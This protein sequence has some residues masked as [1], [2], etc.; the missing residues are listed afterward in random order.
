[1]FYRYVDDCLLFAKSSADAALIHERFNNA[2]TYVKYEIEHPKPDGSLSLLDFNLSLTENGPRFLPFTKPSKKNI[3]MAGD[4][5]LPATVKQRIVV[6][7]WNRLRDRCSSSNS[8]VNQ[9]KSFVDKLR[10]NNHSSIPKLSLQPSQPRLNNNDLPIFYLSI[11]FVD[12]VSNTMFKR[13]VRHLGP[14]S[15]RIC[16]KSQDL[17]QMLH[18]KKNYIPARKG[19][20]DLPNCTL[21]NNLCF[22]SMV[23]YLAT[24]VK[25]NECYI[26]STKKFLHLRVKEHMTMRSSNI[27]QHHALCR[28][29]WKF[30]VLSST[31]SLP[32]LRWQEALWIVKNKPT[33]NK[34]EDF[35]NASLIV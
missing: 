8:K 30:S 13:A 6:N 12:D 23:V 9:R 1:M 29:E 20:C 24:C 15:I 16:H 10:S 35:S 25:C 21:K 3:F 31:R 4:T 33:I 28:S 17:S 19:N 11:P 34:K 27:F 2:D 26:G 18:R 32:N 5:A 7:E 22:R 14:Y